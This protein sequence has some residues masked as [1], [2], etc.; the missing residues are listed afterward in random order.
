M[1]HSLSHELRTPINGSTNMLLAMSE[2]DTIS[3]E[4]KDE[5]INP[6]LNT[7]RVLINIVNDILD[8]FQFDMGRIRLEIQ[9]FDIRQVI[10]ETVLLI[11]RSCDEKKV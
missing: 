5:Y 7:N 4:L 10:Y 6:A 11:Q 1:L 8:F 3:E 2:S 9:S